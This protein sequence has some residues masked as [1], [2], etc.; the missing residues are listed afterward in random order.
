MRHF[1]RYLA[2]RPIV[3]SESGVTAIEYGLIA[4]LIAVVIVAGVTLIGT[5][6]GLVFN[7]VAGKI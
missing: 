1:L 6:L 3:L 7:S 2:G 5:N 4:A